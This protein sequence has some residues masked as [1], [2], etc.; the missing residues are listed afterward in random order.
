MLGCFLHERTGAAR[1]RPQ[2]DDCRGGLDVPRR[3]QSQA[4]GGPDH[5]GDL[6]PAEAGADRLGRGDDEAE[7]LTLRVGGSVDG[8]APRGQQH[9]QRL[10]VAATARGSELGAGEGLAGG[11]DRVQWVGLRAVASLGPLWSVEL[12]HDLLAPFEVSCQSGAVAPGALDRPRPQHRVLV[13]ELNELGISI[14]AGF[15]SDL[16]K[17]PAG[18]RVDRSRGVGVDMGV[19]ADD[20]IDHIA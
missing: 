15:D 8:R 18:P 7:Q 4:R 14:S 2:C 5:R 13:G 11:T 10:T 3:V 19:N 6:R 16:S 12:D 1:Q 9:R 17:H 20:D